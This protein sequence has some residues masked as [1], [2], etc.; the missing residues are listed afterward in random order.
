MSLIVLLPKYTY[1]VVGMFYF[2]TIFVT[3]QKNKGDQKF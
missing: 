2:N 1:G 3:Y